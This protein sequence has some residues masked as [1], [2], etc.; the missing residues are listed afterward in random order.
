MVDR[1]CGAERVEM[2]CLPKWVRERTRGVG[3]RLL[4]VCTR[5]AVQIA[6]SLATLPISIGCTTPQPP[7]PKLISEVRPAGLP[8]PTVERHI[9]R[10]T[11]LT[12]LADKSSIDHIRLIPIQKGASLREGEIPEYRVFGVRPDSAYALLGLENTDILVAADD[13]IIYDPR[14]FP[15]YVTL[16]ANQTQAKLE[17]RRG[18]QGLVVKSLFGE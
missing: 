2:W 8:I 3:T 10:T 4:V 15:L 7:Q 14:T 13:F 11:L 17:I 9:D 6:L 12:S 5:G 16:L 18:S 1:V